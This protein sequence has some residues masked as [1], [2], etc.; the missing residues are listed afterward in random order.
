MHHTSNLLKALDLIY[1]FSSFHLFSSKGGAKTV[2]YH[3]PLNFCNE[4]L[5]AYKL[6]S[7]IED[8]SIHEDY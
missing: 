5:S 2:V 8:L 3:V 4:L 1:F 6:A 7:V